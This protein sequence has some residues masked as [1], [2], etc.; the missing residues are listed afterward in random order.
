[1][2]LRSYQDENI[3]AQIIVLA[4]NAGTKVLFTSPHYSDLQQIEKVWAKIK[5]AVAN[6]YDKN[7]TLRDVRNRLDTQFN[8][9]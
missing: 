2:L 4:E 8:F 6:D 7:T 3:Q 5:G 9:Y 1:M